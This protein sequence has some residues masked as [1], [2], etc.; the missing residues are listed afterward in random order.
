MSDRR[1]NRGYHVSSF[2]ISTNSF[3]DQIQLFYFSFL[4]SFL[5]MNYKLGN[6]GRCKIKLQTN[7]TFLFF[8]PFLFSSF[9]LNIF[10]YNKC[11][12]SSRLLNTTFAI[13]LT[14]NSLFFSF[15]FLCCFSLHFKTLS[16]MDYL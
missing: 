14:T 8:Q 7:P 13:Y 4:L 10:I 2:A 16:S 5:W 11:T 6:N 15:L 9:V 1:V 3:F 12:H